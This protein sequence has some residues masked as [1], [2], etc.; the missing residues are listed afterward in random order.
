VSAAYPRIDDDLAAEVHAA[1]GVARHDSV[2]AVTTAFRG[3]LPAGSTAKW[4][5][6][7]RGASPP[8]TDPSTAL[9]ARLAG[10]FESW[11]CWPFCTGLGA[12]LASAGHDV[13]VLVEHL[14]QGQQVPLVDYH[15]VLVVDG[16]LLDPYLGPSAPVA[17]GED[18]TRRDAWAAWVPGVRADH[19]G[20]RGGSTP[21]RYR[22]L[23]DHLD[24]RD[25]AAFCAVSATHSGV[26]RRRT[27]HWLRGGRLWF[28]REGDDGRAQLRVTEGTNPFEQRR[29]VVATGPFEELRCRIL[30]PDAAAAAQVRP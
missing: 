28:V 4:A 26:G 10:S 11:S 17:A 16:A 30:E 22:E 1:L 23:A 13:R 15:S 14:R 29:R 21:F 2:E 24:A 3:W 9:E 6:V 5:A 20:A 27:A 18:V 19:L 7:D 25:I 8:G 12:V